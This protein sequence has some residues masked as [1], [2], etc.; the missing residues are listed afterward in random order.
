MLAILL[1]FSIS[2]KARGEEEARASI[3][4]DKA[5]IEIDVPK[6][7][8][9]LSDSALKKLNV[10]FVKYSGSGVSSLP[11][12]ALLEYQNH[13]AVFLQDNAGFIELV[14]VVVSQRTLEKIKVSATKFTSADQI[15]VSGVA[16]L[17]AAYLD[18]F[19]AETAHAD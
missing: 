5:I 2:P 9:K 8:F 17:R 12:A 6:K 11:I 3:G 13:T 14:E 7:R 18:I 4:P 10:K 1:S 16:L 15:A 19:D